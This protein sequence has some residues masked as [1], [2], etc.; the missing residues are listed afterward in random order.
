M[1]AGAAW[2]GPKPW[3]GPKHQQKLVGVNSFASKM[4]CGRHNAALSPLDTVASE[5]FVHL[6]DDLLDMLCH[7][8]T[9][10]IKQGF[11]L[12]NG[13]LLE[14]WLL[15]VLW[16]AIKGGAVRVNGSVGYRFRLGVSDELLT[17]I[18]WRGA[19]WP[20]HWGWYFFPDN[21]DVDQ[22]VKHN[23]ASIRMASDG[24][25]VLGGFVQLAG[26]EFGIAFELP[27]VN[28]IYRPAALTFD[29]IGLRGWKIVAFAWP[30]S[31]HELANFHS[32]QPPGANPFVP[33]NPKA[34]NNVG[35]SVPGSV[36]VTPADHSNRRPR[37]TKTNPRA[38][39]STSRCLLSVNRLP[40][41]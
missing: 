23:S 34:A 19:A 9:D 38:H 4:L 20:K 25:E 41:E 28:R 2:Q 36:Q 7:E 1:V 17:E 27:P 10:D 12:V 11:T 18:L 6:R 5:F 35:K 40:V 39:R 16:G 13:P 26:I 33:P 14:L 8:G 15:K 32:Q 30:E 31:G 24:S 21:V 37:R 29:R 3:Q 22:S